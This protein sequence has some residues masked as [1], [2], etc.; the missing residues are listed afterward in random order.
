[1]PQERSFSSFNRLSGI[2]LK[3]K[4]KGKMSEVSGLLEAEYQRL[5]LF[6]TS[7]EDR[8]KKKT[9]KMNIFRWDSER[10]IPIGRVVKRSQGV[11]REGMKSFN[12]GRG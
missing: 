1:M 5:F 9:A 2:G 10:S 12:E 7:T 6:F 4:T 11:S 8:R 3:M